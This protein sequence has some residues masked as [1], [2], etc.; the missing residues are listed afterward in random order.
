MVIN[1]KKA[2]QRFL[3]PAGVKI[4]GKNPWDIQVHDDKLFFRLFSQGSLGVGEAYMDGS[5]DCKQLDRLFTRLLSA[6]LDKKAR[7]PSHFFNH[8]R[9][10]VLNVQT[11]RRSKKVAEQHYDLGNDFYED[12]LDKRMQYTCAYWKNAKNLDQAQENKLKLICEKLGLKKSDKVLELGCGWGGFAKYAAEKYGCSVT[13]YNISAEQVKY[14]REKCKGLPVK[15]VHSDYRDAKGMFDKVVSIGLCEHV[16]H[17]NYNNLMETAH[18]CLK[19]R[20]LFLLHT[21]GGN[22]STTHTEP[23]IEKYIFPNS[24]IPSLKQLFTASEELFVT[25]DFHNIGPD[26]DKTLM[27]WFKNFDKNWHKHKDEYGERFYR[28]W[29]YYLLACAGSFRAR[30]NQLW[31]IVYS[32]GGVPGGYEPIR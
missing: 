27:A 24:M 1:L 25:E 20:G 11:K 9:S 12:M 28:M 15:I 6:N 5:W 17:K 29:K 10:S 23:W 14:A 31:Q 18:G 13:A 21:I 30:R 32:K 26:Y 3:D 22:Y 7:G 8:A 4:N 19:N 16:G 2:A